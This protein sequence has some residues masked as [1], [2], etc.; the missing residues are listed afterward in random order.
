MPSHS[1]STLRRQ[2]IYFML[3]LAGVLALAILISAALTARL[4][5]GPVSIAFFG[6]SLRESLS[7]LVYYAY[8]I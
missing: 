5:V 6:P 2:R 4:A 8:D 7:K 3:A 1:T